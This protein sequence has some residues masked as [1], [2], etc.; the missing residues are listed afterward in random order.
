MRTLGT[1][2]LGLSLSL[3]FVS[4][5]PLALSVLSG[6]LTLLMTAGDDDELDDEIDLDEGA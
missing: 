2:L 5:W 1:L 3:F 6:G 4:P